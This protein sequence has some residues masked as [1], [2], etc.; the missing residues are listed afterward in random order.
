MLAIDP[1]LA[2]HG[3]ESTYGNYGCRCDECRAA[4][5]KACK[6]RRL[7]RLERKR[8]EATA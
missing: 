1:T 4:W 6:L 5:V 2:A 3:R 8:R 7:R